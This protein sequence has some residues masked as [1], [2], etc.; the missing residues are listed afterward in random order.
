MTDC[1]FIRKLSTTLS[2]AFE[3]VHAGT[4]EAQ[5]F[6]KCGHLNDLFFCSVVSAHKSVLKDDSGESSTPAFLLCL[7]I[8]L[9][10]LVAENKL[11][12]V[13]YSRR[14]YE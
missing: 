7:E 5:T 14:I 3:N 8:N 1:P 2:L 11:G 4:H 13:V 12:R 9:T 6:E 10:L